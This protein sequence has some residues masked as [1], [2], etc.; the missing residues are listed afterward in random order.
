MSCASGTY[1]TGIG[2]VAA[3][4]CSGG[5][6]PM[7]QQQ[8]K[9]ATVV[10]ATVASMV[11]GISAAGAVGA[12]VGVSAGGS[13]G[14]SIFQLIQATQFMNIF[15]KVIGKSASRGGGGRRDLS[16]ASN[17]SSTDSGG[18]A[19]GEDSGGDEGGGDDANE[20]RCVHICRAI[21]VPKCI[22]LNK[23]VGQGCKGRSEPW[24]ARSV[25]SRD[26]V[27]HCSPFQHSSFFYC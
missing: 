5:L 16:V 4:N 22:S 21:R 23:K 7:L 8:A 10:V 25:L 17:A 19:G 2:G 12:A 11:V 9:A 6:S 26:F 15:G 13:G 1:F 18:D 24:Y 20:F 14:A 27:F 3:R